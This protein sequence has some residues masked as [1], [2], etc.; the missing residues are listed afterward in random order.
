VDPVSEPVTVT[1]SA[2]EIRSGEAQPR[3][4]TLSDNR[5]L[6][7]AAGET[8]STG[9]V[10]ITA[11]DNDRRGSNCCTWETDVDVTVS[12]TVT[13]P[14]KPTAKPAGVTISDDEPVGGL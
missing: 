14:A 10:T 3:L 5:T 4:F 12:G 13:G 2:V 11:V 8:K 6:T 1:V 9:V 7:V